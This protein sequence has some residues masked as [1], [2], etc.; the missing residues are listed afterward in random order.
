MFLLGVLVSIIAL[1][2]TA[3]TFRL[4][5]LLPNYEV[6]AEQRTPKR[7]SPSG[8]VRLM[9]V[10]GSGG[11]TAEM[12]ELLKDLD[13]TRYTHRS[14]VVSSGDAFS[15]QKAQEFEQRLASRHQ[16][17]DGTYNIDI[18]PR[19]RRIHQ[20]LLTTPLSSLLCLW[21]CINLLRKPALSNQRLTYPDV[22]ITNGPGTGVV[23]VLASYIVRFL[24]ARN[25]EGKM[26]TVYVESWARVKR[27]SLSGKILF[28][29]V[30]RFI[31]QWNALAKATGSKAEYLGVLV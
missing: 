1:L 21:S 12:L 30:N 5:T 22:I 3:V 24:G 15:A 2:S 25:T 28:P 11:H 26:R 19:A 16:N 17:A 7:L 10:L 6:P 14:Y 27:L 13:I 20:S 9:V 29:V 31:V 23:V 8:P 18:V 4:I